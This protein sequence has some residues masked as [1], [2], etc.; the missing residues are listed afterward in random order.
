M[1]LLVSRVATNRIQTLGSGRMS[2][3]ACLL[4]GSFRRG[5]PA[6]PVPVEAG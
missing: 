2:G 6:A 1:R 5:S 3:V 4:G